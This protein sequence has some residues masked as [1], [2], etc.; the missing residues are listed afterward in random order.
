LRLRAMWVAAVNR[1]RRGTR[2]LWARDAEYRQSCVEVPRAR[3]AQ[4]AM[5]RR[6]ELPLSSA[7]DRE[8]GLSSGHALRRRCC[9][10]EGCLKDTGEM[11]AGYAGAKSTSKSAIGSTRTP[12][13]NTL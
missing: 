3:S 6:M 9:D 10:A 11:T 8:P 5:I 13:P 12:L 1:R 4:W 2:V 7:C